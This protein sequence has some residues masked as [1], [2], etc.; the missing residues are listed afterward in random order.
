[1]SEAEFTPVSPPVAILGALLGQREGYVSGTQLAAQLGI[2]RVA[3]WKHLRRL[4][5]QGFRFEAARRRG[6][7]LLEVPDH[8]HPLLLEALLPPERRPPTFLFFTS[9]DSTNTR[10]DRALAEGHPDPIVVVARAQEA[11]RGRLGRSWHSGDHGNLYLSLGLRPRLPPARMGLFTLWMGVSAGSY[12]RGTTGL[13]LGLKWPNDLMADGKKVAGMLT[14]AKMDA[15]QTRETV[16]GLGL[17]I[18]APADTF[19]AELRSLA[20]SLAIEHGSPLPANPLAAG[21]IARLLEAYETFLRDGHRDPLADLWPQFDLLKGR[22][23]TLHQGTSTFS[24]T[25]AG[26][27]A[28]GSLILKS[29]SGGLQTFRAGEVTIAKTAAP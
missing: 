8:L 4:E 7:R 27:D 23:I 10:A 11:G 28:R 17:N 25:A 2:S 26:I 3:V 14:E 22:P 1:M 29:P 20:T 16:F 13:P 19:P 9:T 5:R 6:H 12:L 21:L 24:G 18:N 15:D